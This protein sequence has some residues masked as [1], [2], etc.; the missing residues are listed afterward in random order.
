MTNALL[1]MEEKDLMHGINALLFNK[2]GELLLAKRAGERQ[3]AG[4]WSLVGG[5]Q[6][7]GETVFEAMARELK[8]EIGIDAPIEKMSLVN[9]ADCIDSPTIHFVQFGVKVD[10]WSGEI[11]NKEPDKCSD[12]KFFPLDQIP[13]NLFY[14]TKTNIDLFLNN[15]FYNPEYNYIGENT[16]E[17]FQIEK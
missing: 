2:N 1:A 12:I 4:Q 5:K 3:G 13:E 16:Q 10:D 7:V 15:E 9:V 6:K 14:A 8:E 17:N 11:E